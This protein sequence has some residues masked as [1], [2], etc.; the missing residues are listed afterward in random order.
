[1]VI[2]IARSR[3]HRS[4]GEGLQIIGYEILV[5]A[6]GLPLVIVYAHFLARAVVYT[7]EDVD[8]VIV[9]LRAVEESG[10]RHVL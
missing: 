10:V 7:A 3:S 5:G 8:R 1:M 2:I 6:H 9:V 4:R